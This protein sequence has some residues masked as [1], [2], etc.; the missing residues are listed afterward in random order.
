[1]AL[2][3]QGT[4]IRFIEKPCHGMDGDFVVRMQM[5]EHDCPPHQRGL[6]IYRPDGEWY[7][8]VYFSTQVCS[9]PTFTTDD[10][11][12]CF[13]IKG[14]GTYPGEK[15]DPATGHLRQPVP[16]ARDGC[17]HRPLQTT[18]PLR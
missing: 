18:R 8:F 14:F 4:I 9:S 2:W 11:M 5:C 3:R 12:Y 6:K 16:L 17:R 10:A 7:G 13:K 1:M 15:V